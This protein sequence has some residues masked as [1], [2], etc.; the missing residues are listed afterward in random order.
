MQSVSNNRSSALAPGVIDALVDMIGFHDPEILVELM[1]TFLDD[2]V[3]LVGTLHDQWQ[4]GNRAEVLR[5]AHS[6]KST[7]ATFQA[8]RLSHL[9]AE[10][11]AE[12][13]KDTP[14]IEVDSHIQ[15]IVAEYA[16][17]QD[18]LNVE[19]QKLMDSM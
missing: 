7:S 17:V 19:K 4:A 2:S 8:N 6:L 11:E 13:R 3:E 14:A 5:I 15:S 9:S 18:A 16:V 1:N 10:L 12:L